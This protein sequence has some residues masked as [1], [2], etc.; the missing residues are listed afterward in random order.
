MHGHRV[1]SITV[2]RGFT[3]TKVIEVLLPLNVTAIA[4]D[5]MADSQLE[6]LTRALKSIQQLKHSV[7]YVFQSLSEGVTDRE[8]SDCKD[9]F[10]N[11]LQNDLS[12]VHKTL[13]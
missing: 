10:L 6:N 1:N 5:N 7:R 9:K 2:F 12:S 3:T 11:N 13:K 4:D 8:S